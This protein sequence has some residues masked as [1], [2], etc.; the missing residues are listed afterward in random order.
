MV[1]ATICL[2]VS[3][4]RAQNADAGGATQD[5]VFPSHVNGQIWLVAGEPGESNVAVQVGDDGA[6]VVDTGTQAAAPKL[7]AA[8]QGVIRQ[9]A[10]DRKA[11]SV[12]IDTNGRLDHI[13]G[14]AVIA[15]AGTQIMGGHEAADAKEFAGESEQ[16]A[17]V[18][19]EQSVLTRLVQEQDASGPHA[20][21]ALWPTITEDFD[22]Y[23]MTFDG[24]AVQVYHPHYANT[25]GQLMVFFRQSNVI[26]AGD[27]VDMRTYP[28]IDVARGGT[29]DGELVALNK[30]IE[31]AVPAAF[32]EGGT[33]VIP[34]HGALCDQADVESYKNM[35]T[36]IRNRIQFYKNE[37]KSLEQVLALKPSAGWDERWGATSGPGSTRDFITAVYRTLPAKGPPF[38]MHTVTLVPS[39]ATVS[40]GRQY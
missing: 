28:I 9:H 13:G 32:A 19:A 17:E 2:T 18:L 26:A 14:N 31:M 38:S 7:L 21:Q 20:P 29:I 11:L 3:V 12:I 40:G 37:G 25:D 22:L 35:I 39:T 30:L 34:G 5:S 16:A 15:R 27:V 36:T 24:E 4:V 8:I 6:L 33:M 1:L 23:N 10:G